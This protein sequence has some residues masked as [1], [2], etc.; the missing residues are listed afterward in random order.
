MIPMAKKDIGMFSTRIKCQRL[1]GQASHGNPLSMQEFM[2]PLN[3]FSDI[4]SV[5]HGPISYL[6]SQSYILT[7]YE[8]YYN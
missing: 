5:W 1:V 8:S 2:G 7:I 4:E 6:L 3:K